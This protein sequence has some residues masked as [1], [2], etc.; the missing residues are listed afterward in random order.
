MSG[1]NVIIARDTN[2]LLDILNPVS[3]NA[4]SSYSRSISV[5]GDNVAQ[6]QSSNW[7]KENALIMETI[8]ALKNEP[9]YSWGKSI[10]GEKIDQTKVEEALFDVC[11]NVKIITSQVSMHLQE[12]WREKLFH[13]I[14]L[15][16]DPEGWDE[17]DSFINIDSFKV[18]L[19]W[20]T[21]IKFTRGPGIGLSPEGYLVAAWTNGNDKLTLEFLP[22]RKINWITTIYID[23]DPER[24]TG[25][26]TVSRLNSVLS[27]YDPPSHFYNKG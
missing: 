12:G 18:F 22:N 20:I 10:Q 9:T 6:P 24:S 8:E 4:L 7:D 16:H 11:A 1:N 3:G 13:Q 27:P 14:D 5:D 26:T 19:S 25:F 2:Q 21:Q 17:E 15:I 23:D